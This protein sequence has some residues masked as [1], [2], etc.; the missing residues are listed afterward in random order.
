MR[1]SIRLGC[2][3]FSVIAFSVG[4]FGWGPDGHQF[5]NRAAAMHAP[6]EMPAFFRNA[7]D[8]LEYL[9]PE[10]DRWRSPSEPS[11]KNAQEPEHYIDLE[12]LEGFGELPSK[13]FDYYRKL[14]AF[15]L[16]DTP[17]NGAVLA[18]GGDQISARE[19]KQKFLTPESIGLQPW[20]TAEVY[21]R[22]ITA[23]REYR[24]LLKEGKPTTPAEA[25]AIFYAGWL[26]HYVGDG[27]N[28]MHT[29][30]YYNGW[31]GPNPHGYT[32]SK[33]THYEFESRFVHDNIKFDE[34][35][36]RLN[37]ATLIPGDVFSAYLQYLHDSNGLVEKTYQLEKAGAFQGAGTHDGR[38]FVIGRLAAGAQELIDLWYTAWS[39]SEKIPVANKP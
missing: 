13:R 17:P 26:G 21:E 23:F 16:S 38:E 1:I 34:V 37:P 28:P 12:L 35:G 7:V 2:V 3:V 11:L 27:A 24:R 5:V 10:P 6:Q 31:V 25:N 29:T 39:E 19:A 36:S 30:I 33:S 22:L 8:Q 32:V 14:E 4:V 18:I 20:I 9:G 15:R